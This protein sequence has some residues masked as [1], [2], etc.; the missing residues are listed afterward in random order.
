M[1]GSLDEKHTLLGMLP[2]TNRHHC[3][4]IRFFDTPEFCGVNAGVSGV[5]DPLPLSTIY[6]N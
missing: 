6:W 2:S 3:Y 1:C 4:N 5:A